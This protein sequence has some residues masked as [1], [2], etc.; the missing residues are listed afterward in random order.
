MSSRL[1][2]AIEKNDLAAARRALVESPG[3]IGA[4]AHGYTPLMHCALLGRAE[5]VSL[6]LSLGAQPEERDA[7]G[8]CAAD[9]AR[10]RRHDDI[11]SQLTLAAR[12]RADRPFFGAE[13][14]QLLA[15]LLGSDLVDRV[16]RVANQHAGPTPDRD[17]G[18]E[19]APS[20]PAA[21]AEAVAGRPA[22]AQTA[23]DRQP[24]QASLQTK[25]PPPTEKPVRLEDLIGQSDAKSSLDQIIALARVNAER[26]ARGL[27]AHQVTLHAVFSGS[28]GTGKTTFARYY[29]Q[30]IRRLGI[31]AQ[32]QLI[33]VT[34]YQLVAEYEG[35][36]A[37]KTAKLVESARGGVL[38]IDEAYSLKHGQDDRYGQ[39]AIDTLLKLMDDLRH[40]LIV[41]L[42]GYTEPMR[43]F[44]HLNPGLHSRV[45]N[46][47]EFADFTDEE[48]GRIFDGM[49]A[50][51]GMQ[52]AP[53]DRALAVAEILKRK[54]GRHFGNAREVRNLF[55]RAIA[56][57]SARLARLDLK[58]LEPAQLAALQYS[59][60]TEPPD[61]HDAARPEGQGAA[62]SASLAKLDALTGLATAKQAIREVADF[63]A[64]RKLRG[65]GAQAH[66]IGL[67]MVFVGNP[68]T[69]KTT[70]ARLL[71]GI[72]RD[73]GILPGGHL[74][75]VDRG[76]LVGGYEGQTALKTRERVE[77]ALGGVLFIDE[78]Y[79]LT[80]GNDNYGRE[81]VNTLVKCLE[82]FRSQLAIVLS[83]YPAQME[84]FLDANPGLRSRFART[85]LFPDYSDE[86]LVAI[87]RNMAEEHG[88]RLDA[89]AC[90]RLRLLLAAER[91]RSSESFGNARAV[92]RILETAYKRQ[93]SRLMAAGRSAEISPEAL[94]VLSAADLGEPGP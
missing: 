15:G 29:A 79:A 61:D 71:A 28:P 26:R 72:Y 40:E 24:V 42:A 38:F 9:Y 50:R 93:A 49:C 6:L 55:E 7:S 64:I 80:H 52:V 23:S 2:D 27:A 91:L 83:G 92:R 90:A 41:V 45:P 20:L 35:Q 78:A 11:A 56:Q 88:Y 68:G 51:S 32:G 77:E 48:L 81:A 12:P 39:E 76:G 8:H 53:P 22:A 69:G 30:E 87:G 18:R 58:S 94:A 70:L 65:A 3:L 63:Y 1:I 10:A 17:P 47:I 43:E 36:T 33:E 13:E 34:R 19:N 67:H 4:D 66:D 16:L 25:E 44:L 31:L 62:V 75:E 5:L 21:P 84:R 37:S 59:D 54:K 60:F 86:E 74:V 57:Q 82:D 89:D 73:L 14:R 46:L 85:L